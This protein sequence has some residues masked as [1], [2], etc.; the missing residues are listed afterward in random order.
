MTQP[1]GPAQVVGEQLVDHVVEIM[2]G[3]FSQDPLWAWAF[4]DPERRQDQHRHLWRL[5]VEGAIRYPWVWLNAARTAASVWIPPDGT[6]FAPEQEERFT[7]LVV[8]QTGAGADR[9]F[10]AF[11]T[12]EV[13]HPRSQPHFYLSLLGTAPAHRGHGHGLALLAENLRRVDQLG[14]PAYL[15]ASNLVNV[16]L[17]ARY[18]FVHLQTLELP[19][20]GPEVATM[21]RDPR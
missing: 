8:A 14:A 21:W 2:V 12:L 3:A 6:E 19:D 10:Q 11:G 18:G 9:V 16:P 4:P 15:E 13:A 5:F 1:D 20:G 17:Y 7:E